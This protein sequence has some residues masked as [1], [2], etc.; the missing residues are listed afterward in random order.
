MASD[1]TEFGGKVQRN[2]VQPPPHVP[3]ANERLSLTYRT[4]DPSGRTDPDDGEIFAG[5]RTT[6]AQRAA[7]EAAGA[8]VKGTVAEELAILAAAELAA[9]EAQKAPE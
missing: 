2:G 6:V 7:M 8:F 5:L 1:D 4:G 9:L 3:T